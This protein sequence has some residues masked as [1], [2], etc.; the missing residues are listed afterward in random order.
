MPQAASEHFVNW[1]N[2]RCRFLRDLEEK[3]Q[4]VLQK[5]SDTAQYKALMREKALFLQALPE[6][7]ETYL[8]DLPEAVADVAAERLDTFSRS[9]SQSLRIDSVFFM[10]ALLYPDDH[11]PGEPNNLERL[12]AEVAALAKK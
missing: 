9:A 12:A 7:A 5:S 10:Y 8:D 4:Q 3:A 1:L 6:E 2:G 11:K